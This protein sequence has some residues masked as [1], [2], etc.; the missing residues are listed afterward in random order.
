MLYPTN[1]YCKIC[2]LYF[3]DSKSK[4][5]HFIKTHGVFGTKCK[6]NCGCC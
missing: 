2:N 3:K 4:Q 1:F 6:T 5:L